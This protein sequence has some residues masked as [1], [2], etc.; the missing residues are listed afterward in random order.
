M[1]SRVIAPH[2]VSLAALV[3]SITVN[4][5]TQ[6][7]DENAYNPVPSPD[8]KKIAA[9]RTGWQR[10]GGSGGM[11]RSNLVSDLIL[12]DREG[13]TLSSKPL[14]DGFITNWVKAGIVVFRDWSYS[15]ISAEGSPLQ[16]GRVCPERSMAGPPPTCTERAAYLSTINSFVWVFQ[17]FGD[18]VLMTP[19]GDLSSHNHEKFLGEWLVPSPDE[20]HIAVGPGRLGRSL[21]IYDLRE[22]TWIELGNA[23]IHP[24]PGWNWMEPSWSPWFTDGSQIAFF[25]GDGLV[26]SSPD[27][28]QQSNV[29]HTKEPAGLAVPSP[30]GRMIAYATFTSRPRTGGAGNQPIWSCTGIWVL[31]LQESSQ[32]RRLVGATSDLTYDLRWL[33]NE[34][35]VFDRVDSGAPI[36]PK[37]RLWVVDAVR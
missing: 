28:K 22:K 25:N 16:K 5:Q 36:P 35:L 37:A 7:S 6:L 14:A 9:V 27:G 21:A 11:G 10:P 19:S 8:G 1:R 34:H 26:V 12:L 29:V 3:F 15:L 20:R 4:A 33:D 32:P 2:H 30:D 17:S 23:T 13:H 24:D 18:S 31:G